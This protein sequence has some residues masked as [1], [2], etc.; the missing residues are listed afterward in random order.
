MALKTDNLV[1]S[2][3][4]TVQ[5]QPIQS[6]TQDYSLTREELQFLL[7]MI[8]QS[9]FQGEAIEML[10]KLVIKLQNQYITIK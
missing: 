2:S 7:A 1:V 4:Q 10:Y 9:T 6:P 5:P 3:E 8:K